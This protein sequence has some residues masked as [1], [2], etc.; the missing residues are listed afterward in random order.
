MITLPQVYDMFTALPQGGYITADS[1]IEKGLMYAII[2][3]AKNKAIQITYGQTKRTNPMWYV[4]FYPE[5]EATQ[6][7]DPCYRKFRMPDYPLL[8]GLGSAIGYIGATGKI[9]TFIPIEGRVQ[10]ENYMNHPILKA[11]GK[12][13]YIL[14]ESGWAEVYGSV[15]DFK[16]MIMPSDPRDIPTYNENIDPYPVDGALLEM[17]VKIAQNP[18]L[19]MISKTPYDRIQ[20]GRDNTSVNP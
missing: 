20:D 4:P 14:I 19:V 12:D 10:F 2:N 5:Y 8:D 16:M 11:R 13:I 7:T 17:M 15:R 6:Q 9:N 18:D 1:R 3:K